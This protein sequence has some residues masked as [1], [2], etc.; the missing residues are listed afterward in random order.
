MALKQ[1]KKSEIIRL[2]QV[3][4]IINENTILANLNHPFIVICPSIL[5]E[6]VSDHHK[7]KTPFMDQGPGTHCVSSLALQKLINISFYFFF[8]FNMRN[9]KKK[10]I[11][12]SL[13]HQY[14]IPHNSQVSFDGFCQDSRYLYLIL[15][16]IS[17]GE[18]FTYLRSVGRLETDH[19]W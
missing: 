3:D 9:K 14:S 19:A 12:P 1:L 2:K 10:C 17:G 11:S 15:E 16:F 4:H 6:K 7:L 13:N 5:P 18:L 8:Y